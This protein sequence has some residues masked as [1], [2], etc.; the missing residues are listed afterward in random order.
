MGFRPGWEWLLVVL[1]IVVLFGAK[2][3]PDASRSIGR[4]MRILKS[5]VKGMKDDDNADKSARP[6]PPTTT[7]AQVEPPVVP[8]P[9]PA[10]A[11]PV[12]PPVSGQSRQP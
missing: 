4:S 11:S 2:R 5:E 6:T 3:L 8:A 1:V 10:P 7:T 12:T 9:A